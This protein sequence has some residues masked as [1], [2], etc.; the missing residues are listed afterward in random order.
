M[1]DPVAC[2]RNPRFHPL[3]VNRIIGH[4]A[5][6]GFEIAERDRIGVMIGPRP[7][8]DAR[9]AGAAKEE[10]GGVAAGAWIGCSRHWLRRALSCRWKPSGRSEEHTSELQSLMR[11]SYAVFC[12]KK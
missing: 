6:A 2:D 1:L 5:V 11:N 8:P 9:T 12:V 4:E 3:F 7:I 10:V